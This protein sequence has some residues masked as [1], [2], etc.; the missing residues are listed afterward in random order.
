M[1]L[2]FVVF[3]VV[4][5]FVLVVLLFDVGALG[6]GMVLG[7]QSFSVCALL[8]ASCCSSNSLQKQSFT[9]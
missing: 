5:V 4:V 9:S 3:L 7:P 6:L 1:S 2:F 8:W